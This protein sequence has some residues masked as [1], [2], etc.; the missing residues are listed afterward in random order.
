MADLD[1]LLAGRQLIDA[2]RERQ[3]QLPIVDESAKLLSDIQALGFEDLS[4]FYKFN[5]QL[6]REEY[7]KKCTIEGECDLCAGYK[8]VPPCKKFYGALSCSTRGVPATKENIRRDMFHAI[9]RGYLLGEGGAKR[10]LTMDTFR[11]LR[12][13]GKPLQAF[14][15]PG[16]GFY[17]G[18]MEPLDFDVFWR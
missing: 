15:P 16:H 11:R 10:P 4:D 3:A 9:N 8:G 14:C 1:S 17:G 7:D 5:S 18:R 2:Y 12:D 6:C 13:T